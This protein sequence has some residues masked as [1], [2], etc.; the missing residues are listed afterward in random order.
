MAKKKLTQEEKIEQLIQESKYHSWCVVDTENVFAFNG[1]DFKID[2]SVKQY[3]VKSDN[4]AEM[5]SIL[6]IDDGDSI[7]FFDQ[8][9]KELNEKFVELL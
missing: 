8:N 5:D 6:C 4:E 9:L 1:F 2:S 7:R 3:I